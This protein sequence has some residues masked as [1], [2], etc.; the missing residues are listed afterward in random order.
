MSKMPA[1]KPKQVLKALL[2]AGFYVHHQT[3]GHAHLRNDAKP[4]VRVTI[5][6]HARCDLPA[7]ILASILKQACLERDEFLA[8]L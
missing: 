2:R 3:G 1:L 7:P 4:G 5:P 8:M 6:C